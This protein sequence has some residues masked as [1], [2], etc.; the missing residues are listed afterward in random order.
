[1]YLERFLQLAFLVIDPTSLPS[2]FGCHA[3]HPGI[4]RLDQ[5]QSRTAPGPV[6][7]TLPI[8]THSLG[9]HLRSFLED[10]WSPRDWVSGNLPM[11]IHTFTA[12]EG[13]RGHIHTRPALR[14]RH[15]GSRQT[16]MLMWPWSELGAFGGSVTS[17]TSILVSGVPSWVDH[18]DSSVP[19]GPASRLPGSRPS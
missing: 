12:L 16:Y 17:A 15:C 10:T 8:Y 5:N 6:Y 4:E 3:G 1:M 18:G 2:G 7:Q 9:L 19:E 14:S 13:E 11:K